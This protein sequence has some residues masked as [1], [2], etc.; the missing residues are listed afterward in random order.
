V[1]RVNFNVGFG[2][3]RLAMHEQSLWHSQGPNSALDGNVEP[4]NK[5]EAQAIIDAVTVWA[6]ERDDIR[7]MALAGSWARGNPRHI[8]LLFLTDRAE[9]YQRRRK[10]LTEIDIRNA[11]YRIQ[12]SESAVYGVVWSRHLHLLPPATWN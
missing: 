2:I 8:D 12:S 6:I 4:M 7:A 10:W 5:A 9:E 3:A 11:G 1:A